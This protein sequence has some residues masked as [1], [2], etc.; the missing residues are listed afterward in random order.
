M[1]EAFAV[2]GKVALYLEKADAGPDLG[3]RTGDTIGLKVTASG[4]GRAFYYVPG[5]AKV[6]ADLAHRLE[7]R[8]ARLLRRHALHRR[9]DDPA[10]PA[11]QDRPRM[12]HISMSGPDGSIAAFRD[13]GVR[14][15]VFVHINNSN[16]VLDEKSAER[17]ATEA[18]GW[19]VGY[20]GMEIR[21]ERAPPG[22]PPL[23]EP[24]SPEEFEAAVRAVGA[25]RYHD[26]HPFHRS[27]TAASSTRA[28]AGLGAQPLLLPGRGPA[29]RMPRCLRARGPPAAARLDRTACSSTTAW[30]R[31]PAASSAGSC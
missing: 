3:T 31:S 20:D 15:K 7:G 10:G 18:A 24:M 14:R 28:G 11:R 25:E 6:D 5:C 19:E 12:G 26:K 17:K 27:C 16:P 30:A 1:V 29:A 2:P 9:R 4:S 8:G 21:Y 13:L 23:A 22:K